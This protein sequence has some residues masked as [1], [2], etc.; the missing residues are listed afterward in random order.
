ML[1]ADFS[2]AP[3]IDRADLKARGAILIWNPTD[4]GKMPAHLAQIANGAP[5][6]QPIVIPVANGRFKF[7]FGWAIVPPS[8]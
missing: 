3:W 7:H 1:D 5:Q 8:E 4:D 2:K 6:H